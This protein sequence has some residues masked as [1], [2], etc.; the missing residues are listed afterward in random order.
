MSKTCATCGA[1]TV[2]YSHSF[3]C[4]LAEGLKILA[5]AGGGPINLKHL[6]L[7][8]NQ[9]DNFQKLRYWDLVAR[10]LERGV[11][12]ITDR[13]RQFVSGT[14]S[15]KRGVKTF[16]GERVEYSG[17]DILFTDVHPMYQQKPDYGKTAEAV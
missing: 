15:I 9:W 13:G 8:R 4:G 10:T 1:K 16:R 11:W 2:K 6:D 7:T 3:N 12:Q 17:Q 14:I 5:D